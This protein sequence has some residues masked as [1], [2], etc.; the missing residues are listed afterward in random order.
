[1]A[2]A[3][4]TPA[5]SPQNNQLKALIALV[6]LSCVWGITWV[7]SKQA[8]AYAPP[9]AFAAERCIG[10]AFALLVVLRITG[11]RLTLT[12][13]KQT[14]AISLVQVSGFM[15]FQTCALVIGGP[16]KTSVLIF[17]MPIWTLIL[18]RMV[19]GEK[20][21]G[22]QWVAAVSTLTGLLFIISP[23]NLQGNVL[24]DCLGVGAA[25]CWAGGTIL[26]KRFR[27][28]HTV[29]LINLTTW[30]MLIGSLPLIILALV[31]PEH[32][33][34]WTSHYIVLLCVISLISTSLGWWLWIYILDSLPAWEASL[35]V[36]GTPVIAIVSSTLML[37][38]QFKMI[39][40]M[41]ML[42]IGA[43][44]SSLSLFGYLNSKRHVAKQA[45]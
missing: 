2:S 3:D 42:L 22:L 21:R 9:F 35:S 1:M 39:E 45:P 16:G 6:V 10:G 4:S 29:D 38:E 32:P 27:A 18:A 19:L 40:V 26:V 25:M 5:S 37:G 28:N 31:L 14:I 24:G 34:Q 8:L 41:G 15:I 13:P 7:L 44:L 17:T 43:G 23:W 12:A 36:L 30:Q 20:L 11:R 33:T